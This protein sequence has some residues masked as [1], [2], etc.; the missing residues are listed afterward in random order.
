MKLSIFTVATPDFTPEQLAASAQKAGLNSIEWRY[1]EVPKELKDD[2]PSF[3]GNNR[4]SI[5]PDGGDEHYAQFKKITEQY[6]L[7]SLSVTP[8][9]TAGD[10]E[11]TEKVLYAAQKIG[12]QFIRIGGASY[13]RK[14]THRELFEQS[15]AY[16]TEVQPLCKRYG[17]KGLLE[18][19]HGTIAAS[20]SAAYQ[21]CAKFDPDYIG[22]LYDPGNMVHE[23][24]ENYR[25]GM[26]ILGP[27]L[28]HVHI[29]NA[30]WLQTPDLET[31]GSTKWK[32]VWKPLLQ[33]IVPWKQVLEDL[34]FVGYDGYLGLEDFS[35]EYASDE[36]MQ[37]FADYIRSLA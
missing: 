9:L 35:G 12:A 10:V 28:A 20:A 30:V 24:F 23:G 17:I 8:Y 29:K 36:M 32:A 16:M 18:T 4:C 13:D 34:E 1:K 27:Y 6:G 15:L 11:G 5:T 22:V 21:L 7:T 31:D 26:E 37:R 2:K 25:M 3:W 19:H 14:R 33:G